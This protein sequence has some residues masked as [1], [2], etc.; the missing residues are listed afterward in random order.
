MTSASHESTSFHTIRVAV[1]VVTA[2][3]KQYAMTSNF[4]PNMWHHCGKT[5]N[6][7]AVIF[8]RYGMQSGKSF[9]DAL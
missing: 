3:Y 7:N 9:R 6:H 8:L 5:E 4:P 2:I 1:I